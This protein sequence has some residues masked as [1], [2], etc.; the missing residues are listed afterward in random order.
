MSVMKRDLKLLTL[1]AEK[2]MG[3]KVADDIRKMWGLL[4]GKEKPSKE[5]L[6]RMA[7]L[8]GYQSWEDFQ[9]ALHG[10][11]DGQTNYEVEEECH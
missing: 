4:S 8:A 2:R 6:N 1:S 7:L 5:L 10:D 3:K 9:D 11:D